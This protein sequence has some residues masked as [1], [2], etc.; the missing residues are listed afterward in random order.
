LSLQLASSDEPTGTVLNYEAPRTDSGCIKYNRRWVWLLAM[1]AMIA[2]V[3]FIVSLC[4]ASSI[5]QDPMNTYYIYSPP[6]PQVLRV[7]EQPCILVLGYA[8]EPRL[9]PSNA[10]AIFAA[11]NAV[12]WGAAGIGVLYAVL[13]SCEQLF[14]RT[15]RVLAS[16]I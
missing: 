3:H 12:V 7:F 16:W 15:K 8:D 4:L 2:A 14:T 13:W 9:I 1:G 5:Y 10:F 11:V 6:S